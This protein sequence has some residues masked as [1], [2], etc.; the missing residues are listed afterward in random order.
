MVVDLVPRA[1]ARDHRLRQW[2]ALFTFNIDDRVYE[3]LLSPELRACGAAHSGEPLA[4]RQASF[5]SVEAVLPGAG[6]ALVRKASTR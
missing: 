6:V 5:F 4:Y 3:I 1:P 2:F